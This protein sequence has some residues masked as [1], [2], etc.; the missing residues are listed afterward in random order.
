MPYL[1]VDELVAE[2]KDAGG[3]PVD[4]IFVKKAPDYAVY[5]TP[6]RVM[7]Q[8]ADDQVIAQAQRSALAALNPL[9]GQISGLIDGWHTS[10]NENA[11][12]RARRYDR[13]VAD[14][15]VAGLEGTIGDALA[16]LKEI[17]D[18]IVAERKSL[19][20][21]DYLVWAAGFG[22]LLIVATGIMSSPTLSIIRHPLDNM[23][24]IWT[25]VAGGTIGAFFSIATAMRG[26]TILI[27]LQKWDNRRDALLRLGVGTIG[28][29][30]LIC[31]MMTGLVTLGSIGGK[32][33]VAT[34]AAGSTD[35]KLI[36]VVIGFIAGFSER[37]VP[38]ILG[39]ASLAIAE[40]KDSDVAG[41]KAIAAAAPAAQAAEA[42]AVAADVAGA[43]A[44]AL[45]I[46][47]E[48]EAL[49]ESPCDSPPVEG[50]L[51]TIDAELPVAVGGVSE[52]APAPAAPPAKDT[53]KKS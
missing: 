40:A 48:I 4:C 19:A 50:E 15:I 24:L 3:N 29:G 22:I 32:E 8:F 53:G 37:A 45:A 5:R 10:K 11:K 28:A 30:I 27:D 20:Q 25:A 46:D 47:P 33:L 51:L 21:T 1:R 34:A 23:P 39:K 2:Q 52:D 9:R 49:D 38:D 7:V 35:P 6:L 18:D 16:L 44:A 36:A 13:R 42:A 17:R 41:D 31:L 14:A 12:T 43:R 26:R